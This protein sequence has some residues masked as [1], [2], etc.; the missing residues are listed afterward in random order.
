MMEKILKQN[1]EHGKT[2][3]LHSCCAPCSSYVL[4][5]LRKYFRI[6][7]FYYNP[8]ITDDVEYK[9]RV[10]E[11]K[12]LIECLNNEQNEDCYKILVQEGAY[13]PLPFWEISKGHEKDREGGERCFLCYE[14]RLREA[15]LQA[16]EQGFHYF[17]TTLSI[18]PLKNAQQLNA[19]GLRLQEEYG[20]AYLVSDFKKKNGYQ[21]SIQLSKQY[22]LYRQDYCGCIFSKV[23]REAN[24]SVK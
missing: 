19:I 8:N 20:V 6:T 15:A 13:N 9:K 3:F 14:L 24:K 23:E 11:Q 7:V 10:L 5:Y 22:D 21:T 4:I 17:T 18:S 1:S 16:K 12:R 2:L